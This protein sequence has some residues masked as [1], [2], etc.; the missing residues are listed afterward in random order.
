MNL[1]HPSG[2]G[3]HHRRNRDIH[4]LPHPDVALIGV[5]EVEGQLQLPV[6]DQGGH[7]GP[8]AQL[9]IRFKLLD[10]LELAGKG[11]PDGEV[12]HL[13]LQVGQVF[14]QIVQLF[15]GLLQ[16]VSGGLAVDGVQLLAGKNSLAHR[17]KDLLHRSCGV[18]GDGRRLLGYSVAIALD[19][20]LD[21][22][23]AGHVGQRLAGA[24]VLPEDQ[25][26][27]SKATSPYDSQQHTQGDEAF[28]QLLLAPPR[29]LLH[30]GPGGR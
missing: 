12:V 16:I 20:A 2:K 6:V 3:A 19:H 30:R 18:Q 13:F 10:L 28:D 23:D 29:R 17:D 4:R 24:L 14:I 11:S 9:L 26:P 8:C 1:F 21:G 22:V 27:H 5:A 25:I 15:L 7:L